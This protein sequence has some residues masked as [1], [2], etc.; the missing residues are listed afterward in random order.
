[1]QLLG[2]LILRPFNWKIIKI[3][4]GQY[5]LVSQFNSKLAFFASY[6][7]LKYLN[8]NWVQINDPNGEIKK[9][10]DV[11]Y[12]NLSIHNVKNWPNIL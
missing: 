2:T 3:L 8:L 10:I 7:F 4:S 6:V 12:I 1:M 5:S 9:W 11:C